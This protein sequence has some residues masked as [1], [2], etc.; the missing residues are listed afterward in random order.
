MPSRSKSQIRARAS[1]PRTARAFL[2]SSIAAST[3]RR[4]RS[5]GPG[6]GLPWRANWSKPTAG[7]LG[8][9]ARPA[10]APRSGSGCQWWRE[11]V[12]RWP[13]NRLCLP[14]ACRQATTGAEMQEIADD[15]RHVATGATQMSPQGLTVRVVHG[16]A[17]LVRDQVAALLHRAHPGDVLGATDAL[18]ERVLEPE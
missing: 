9:A 15:R 12:R 16:R 4:S 17:R 8:Y 10:A 3:A 11:S 1:R 18:V 14:R 13:R 7:R 6:W 2:R 5:A